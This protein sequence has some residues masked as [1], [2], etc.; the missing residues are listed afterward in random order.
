MRDES[1]A[2]F[3]SAGHKELVPRAAEMRCDSISPLRRPRFLHVKINVIAV[4]YPPLMTMN[5]MCLELSRI[6]TQIRALMD[7]YCRRLL[8]R[9]GDQHDATQP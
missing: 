5:R 1:P 8:L 4:E 6:R 2:I 9:I 7:V 3:V